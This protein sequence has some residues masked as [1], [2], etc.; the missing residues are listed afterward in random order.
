MQGRESPCRE[1]YWQGLPDGCERPWR[2]SRSRL[3]LVV[4]GSGNVERAS[5]P[6]NSAVLLDAR[7]GEALVQQRKVHPFNFS[8][9]DLEL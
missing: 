8:Q 6:A 2:R 1:R 5:P 4:P 9:A 3:R 7:T